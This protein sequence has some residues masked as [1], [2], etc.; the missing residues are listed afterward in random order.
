M[1]CDLLK[2]RPSQI[3][4]QLYAEKNLWDG[5]PHAEK[6]TSHVH[7]SKRGQHNVLYVQP[8]E[9]NEEWSQPLDYASSL[10]SPIQRWS[11]WRGRGGARKIILTVLH[12]RSGPASQGT[13]HP[14]DTLNLI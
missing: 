13:R 14:A 11:L 12:R 7:P 2:L 8:G 1:P 5:S 3:A 9:L 10:S 4:V 6:C